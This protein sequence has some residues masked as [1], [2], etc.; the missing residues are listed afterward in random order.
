MIKK[1]LAGLLIAVIAI[2]FF[3]AP[4]NISDENTYHISGKYA[5]PENVSA[6]LKSAC[7][8]CHSNKTAYPWYAKV[9]P[10]AWFLNDHVTEGKEH[11]NFSEFTNMPIARQNHKLEEIIEMIE[12]KEMPLASYTYLGLHKEADLSDAQRELL[13]IWAKSQMDMLKANYPADSLLMKKR[14]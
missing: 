7:Y 9:Q 12:E 14:T 3:Q 4:K 5:I 2:Q 6:I 1:I 13:I 8:D 11:L 10:V